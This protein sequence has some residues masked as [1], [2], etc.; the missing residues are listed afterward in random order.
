MDA[1]KKQELYTKL[2]EH[3]GAITEVAKRANVSHSYA[4][5]VLT[6]KRKSTRILTVAAELL[7]ELKKEESDHNDKQMQ[8]MEQADLFASH[9]LG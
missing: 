2:K 4:Y 6:G 7:V 8:L 1:Q 9:Y 5:R 3:Y